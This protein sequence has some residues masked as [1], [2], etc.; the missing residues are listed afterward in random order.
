MTPQL[1]RQ[2]LSMAGLAI[3]FGL[4]ALASR[5]GEPW[6]TLSIAA[7]IALLGAA[8]WAYAQGERW[9]QVLAGVL[10]TYALVRAGMTL[11]AYFL[12]LP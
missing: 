7:L 11:M 1:L 10:W 9:I 6:Q 12:A 2:L 3:G 8:A 5:L 4:Y